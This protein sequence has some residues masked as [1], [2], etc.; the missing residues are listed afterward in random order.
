MS[1]FDSLIPDWFK[2]FVQVGND[3]IWSQYLIGL[4]ITAGIFFTIGSKFVQLRWIP[5]MFRAIGEKP[6]T[7]ENGKKGISPFQAF[8][9]SAGSR[10][11]T[12]NIA[13]VATAIVLGGPGAVFWMWI[14]AFIGA[15]SAFIEA[16]LAQVYKVPD[17]E[18]GYRGGPA[19]YITKGLNQKWLG[20]VFAVLITVTFAFVFNTVQSNTIAESLKTQ[21]N[22]SPIVTGIILAIV[23]AIIIFG[24]VRS[25]ATLSSIIVP[26]MA[27]I[28]I[29]LV[30][31]ILIFNY[32]QIIPMIATIVKNAFG[33]EQA[34]GGAVG[35]A[36]LQGIK[37]GL[38][39]NEA[40]MGSAPNAAATAA[41]PHPV[42]QGLIQSLGVFF[43]T[44]LVCTATAIMILLYTGL[45]FGENAAQGV[46]VT[47]SALNEHLGSAGGIF[48]TIAI[49][50]FAFSS[51]IG[52]YYYGQSNMEFLW[53]N[54]TVLFIFRCLVV[55]LVFVG[56]VVKTETVWSTADVF[57][58]LMAIVNLVAIIGLSNIAFAVMNDYQRQRKAGKKPVF[59]PEELEINL[60]GIESWGM[61]K[62]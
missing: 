20:V 26:V 53:E 39:S 62:K 38:F 36:V 30:A 52:N 10:V 24:G 16:T 17:E 51:V 6:E 45:E 49:T 42:K 59:K 47:Q 31:V 27:I 1:N 57:M 48:L 11:G 3:L 8:A 13:G 61:K 21:Y 55:V 19:Y 2:G 40:G 37:R 35:A 7:L 41:A 33:F 46:A 15:A 4:L 60:F 29:G 32:D 9:I 18:G 43:D 50:L 12:G 25:I 56:A 28:Y 22:V 5:E 58:G 23:T 54:K 44:M 14:I 34:T